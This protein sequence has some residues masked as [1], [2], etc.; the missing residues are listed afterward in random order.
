MWSRSVTLDERPTCVNY[1]YRPSVQELTLL[2]Q[3]TG[4]ALLAGFVDGV[5]EL[6]GV[7]I[8]DV[9][10]QIALKGNPLV[11]GAGVLREIHSKNIE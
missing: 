4:C 1:V 11:A 8:R 7:E 2:D 10:G 5:L 9:G 3:L 6:V